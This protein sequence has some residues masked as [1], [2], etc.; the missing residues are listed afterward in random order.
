M[1]HWRDTKWQHFLLSRKKSKH[2]E[3]CIILKGFLE[4]R[5]ALNAVGVSEGFQWIDGSF[6]EHIELIASRSPNDI[7]TVTFFN[8][9]PGDSQG[10]IIAR[11]AA[12]FPATQAGKDAL[13]VTYHVD[14]T[15]LDLKIHSPEQLVAW[16]AYWY[17]V[18]S[19]RRDYSWKGFAQIPLN[20]TEDLAA[21][22]TLL[23]CPHMAGI[24]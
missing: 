18:W 14:A 3:R 23:Q 22:Q 17:G 11:N 21:L 9:L 6:L 2:P 10:S 20:S 7:D 5:I 4:Y 15:Y 12:L 8:L 24:T 1:G 13:K 19:H 16:S